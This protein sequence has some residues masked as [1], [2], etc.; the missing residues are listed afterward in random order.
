MAPMVERRAWLAL[1]VLAGTFG[2]VM[3]SVSV[4]NVAFDALADEFTGTS[5]A[6]LGW[7]ITGYT[8]M[9]AALLIP[10]GRFADTYG[11]R[12]IFI[13]GLIVY[14]VSSVLGGL[15]WSP[16]A[17]IIARVGQGAGAAL[18][19]PTSMTLILST[20]PATMRSTVIGIWG[21]VGAIAAA[22]GPALGGLVVD[23]LGWRWVF[24]LNVPLCLL[25]WAAAKIW[26]DE[27]LA[28]DADGTPDPIGIVF[29][30]AAVGLLA[31]GLSQSG[32]WGWGDARTLVTLV[33]GFML[34]AALIW[35]CRRH[36]VPVLD[37]SLFQHRSFAV[38]N[39][40]TLLFNLAFS[41][42]VLNNVLFLMRVWDYSAAGAGFGIAPS[43]LSA[44]VA[45]QLSGRAAD[46][47]GARALILPGIVMVTAGFVFLAFGIGAEPAYW[48]RWFPA[49]LV[50]G[51][52][53]GMVFAN[54]SS[55]SVADAPPARLAI[56]S[57]TNGSFRA[58][59]TAFG[60]AIV[61]GTIGG[62]T[63]AVAIARFDAVWL[64]AAAFG[65]LSFVL[66]LR[67]PTND[68]QR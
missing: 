49:A 63:G 2:I 11:R 20:F 6:T 18:V 36:P 40:V 13:L 31:L 33:A 58:V 34:A 39:V 50:F 24:W 55:I 38:G 5:E 4:M 35:R 12:R 25:A 42:M 30:A 10:A 53:V 21:S 16:A 45:A 46:R 54:V 9:T 27:H 67:L 29:S 19:T 48:T 28:E 7:V 62:A 32:D 22:G 8:T 65:V 15:G 68:A 64:I 23:Q 37:L 52:G 57:A 61:I 1:A 14:V 56:A 3:I 17:V 44:A 60:P 66:A 47:H 26:L 59:G 51:S 41:A 43:P